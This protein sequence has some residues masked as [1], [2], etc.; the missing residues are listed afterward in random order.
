[1]ILRAP[2]HRTALR[3]FQERCTEPQPATDWPQA[4][5]DCV[6]QLRP[7]AVSI[8]Q[9]DVAGREQQAWE[10]CGLLEQNGDGRFE[11]VDRLSDGFIPLWEADSA[12]PFDLL[13]AD[14]LLLG[15]ETPAYAVAHDARTADRLAR[16]EGMLCL[17]PTLQ[18]M[19]Y[20]AAL[21]MAAATT[22]GREQLALPQIRQLEQLSRPR[23]LS[24]DRDITE[25]AAS[26]PGSGD[27]SAE[28]VAS[29][30]G[31]DQISLPLPEE[32]PVELLLS[33]WSL[34]ADQPTDGELVR[35]LAD[36]LAGA[37]RCLGLDLSGIGVWCPTAE[38]TGVLQT[39][40]EFRESAAL[41]AAILRSLRS[42]A[43]H[44]EAMSA[45]PGSPLARPPADYLSARTVLLEQ[46]RRD[47]SDLPR[48]RQAIADYEQYVEQQIVAPLL[49]Q[50][51]QAANPIAGALQLEV[52]QVSGLLQRQTP[53]L[54]R[55]IADVGQAEMTDRRRPGLEPNVRLY[56]QL[57]DR[58]V[59]LAKALSP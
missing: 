27:L 29:T 39:C 50:G 1:M 28:A 21:G 20:C 12:T 54:L 32:I 55:E 42:R 38:D 3:Q 7:D 41:R 30:A 9:A 56:L 31:T 24:Q 37:Q 6:L 45:A 40:R 19:R 46:L 15:E 26:T 35:L 36:R 11:F 2:S 44:L 48:M 5:S 13:L 53:A 49:Q 33:A 34:A 52:A 16:S 14:G 4:E 59:K 47:P 23:A 17:V 57:L 58:L 10:A 25:P 18:D 51:V 8:L 22:P 43:F